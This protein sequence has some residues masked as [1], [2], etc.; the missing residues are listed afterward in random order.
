MTESSRSFDDLVA[1]A[2]GGDS[3]ALGELLEQHRAR[4][5]LLGRSQLGGRYESRIDE[6]D[7]AQQTFLSAFNGFKQFNGTTPDELA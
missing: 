1:S 3:D 5:R 6:S 7:I 2:R 4:L